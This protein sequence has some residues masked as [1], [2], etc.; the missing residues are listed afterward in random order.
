M[1]EGAEVR[2]KQRFARLNVTATF[3][4][5]LNVA[6]P[7]ALGPFVSNPTSGGTLVDYQQFL[8]VP[9]Q[10]GSAVF[11]WAQRGWHASSAFT[12]AGRNNTLNQPPYTLVDA[13]IGKTLGRID[14]TLAGTNI[15]NAAAGPFTLYQAGVPYRGL[16]A[17][18]HGSQ[19]LANT[20]T[21]ALFVQPGS[22]KFIVTLHE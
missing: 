12:F 22:M 6:Y 17:G 4:Y 21:D 8:G 10:Q 19:Y 1:Y 15:F 2:Y 18:P 3:S 13:A 7:Y 14:F 20:P 5:G 9:Q 11:T 16:Y